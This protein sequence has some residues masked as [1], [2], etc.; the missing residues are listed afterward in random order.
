MLST[1]LLLKNAVY[2]LNSVSWPFP[3]DTSCIWPEMRLWSSSFCHGTV[4]SFTKK[5]M[6]KFLCSFASL[7]GFLILFNTL[8]ATIFSFGSGGSSSELRC[9]TA[10]YVLP[11]VF[12]QYL[13]C[14]GNVYGHLPL[15]VATLWSLLNSG[16]LL[17]YVFVCMFIPDPQ[18]WQ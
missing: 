5:F 17:E 15:D 4:F 11:Q 18:L 7:H 13:T 3:V 8:P 1:C 14:K 12:M 10:P 2:L 6:S 9:S 16:S